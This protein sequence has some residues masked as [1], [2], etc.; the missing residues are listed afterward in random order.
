MNEKLKSIITSS[1][2]LFMAMSSNNVIAQDG[3]DIPSLYCSDSEVEALIVNSRE[4]AISRVSKN[5]MSVNDF[6]N[7]NVFER[8]FGDNAVKDEGACAF[9]TLPKFRSMYSKTKREAKKLM[10]TI[11]SGL[12]GG[13]FGISMPTIDFND[14]MSK[15]ADKMCSATDGLIDTAKEQMRDE[16]QYAVYQKLRDTALSGFISDS[17]FESYVNDQ[18]YDNFSQSKYLEWRGGMSGGAKPREDRAKDDVDDRVRNAVRG[19]F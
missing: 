16:A 9:L 5:R 2:F 4:S 14:I 1:M 13:G 3:K 10:D 6:K 18:L 7:N 17:L 15:L 8:E 11:Q 19:L 12:S